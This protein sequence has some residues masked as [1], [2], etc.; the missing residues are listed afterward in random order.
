M[1]IHDISPPVGATAVSWH[2][3]YGVATTW[4]SRADRGDA[5]T[6]STWC[7]HAHTG[8]HVDAPLHHLAGGDDLDGYD[9]ARGLG[10]CRVVDVPGE[11]PELGADALAAV[12]PRAGERLLLRTVNS[13]RNLLA[14]TEFVPDYAGLTGEAAEYLAQVGVALVGA[15]YLSVEAPGGGAAPA[16]RHLLGAGVTV[17]EGLALRHVAPG[18]YLLLF[19]PLRL[20]GAEAA[21]GRAVLLDDATA[22]SEPEGR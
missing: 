16:H 9:L 10:R 14:R 8:T 13:G 5:T 18:E 22:L 6:N 11:G 7:L 20:S 19:L 12:S 1:R 15:D 3:A 21:P 4:H 2:D 17:L